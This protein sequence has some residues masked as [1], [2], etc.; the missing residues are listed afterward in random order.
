MWKIDRFRRE[1]DGALLVFFALCSAAIFLIAALS[2]DVGRRAVTQTDL[3]SFA[4]NVALAAAGELNGMPGAMSRARRAADELISDTTRFSSDNDLSGLSDFEMTFYRNL[5]NNENNWP[6]ALGFHAGSD[7]NRNDGRA[8]FVRIQVNPVDVEWQFA[9]LLGIFTS[10]PLPDEAVAAE[11]TA[12]Y[13]SVVCDVAPVFFC[14]PPAQPE[15]A[16]AGSTIWDPANH[17]GST[18]LLKAGG[19]GGPNP[20]QVGNFG[21]L[22][23]VGATSDAAKTDPAGACFGI[24][25]AALLHSCLL[26]SISPTTMCFENGNLGFLAASGSG[27]R[28]DAL[29]TKFDIYSALLSTAQGDDRFA[30]APIVTKRHADGATC[31]PGGSGAPDP[32]SYTTDLPADDCFNAG[33]PYAGCERYVDSSGNSPRVGNGDWSEGRLA[34]VDTNYGVDFESFDMVLPE[35]VVDG[36]HLDDPFRPDVTGHPR[37]AANASYPVIPSGAS[38]WNYYNAEVAAGYFASPAL[39]YDATLGEVD[40]SE[41]ERS[42]PRDL[43]S[44]YD[45]D[46]D[47][48]VTARPGSSL[49]QCAADPVL[50]PRRRTLVAAV[51]DCSTN[52]AALNRGQTSGSATWFVELF[53]PGVVGEVAGAGADDFYVEVISG[54]L[55]NGG[56]PLSNGTFR[57]LVQLYR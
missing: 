50:D 56:A 42:S 19:G 1:E 3:Q 26:A 37:N 49:P 23:V 9:N 7:L 53:L 52:G 22:D 14:M 39:A 18:I 20:W 13:T 36:Y 25:D 30:P 29:N 48:N 47:G 6:T 44:D 5:P 28:S 51:V 16:A 38:R 35:E 11:A 55:Q 17:I 8:R 12:G 10:D 43:I 33:A 24:T 15:D 32:T 34:Y 41:A 31:A 54:G 46:I 27:I 2:F 45:P 40:L 57:N 21:Y 4:D